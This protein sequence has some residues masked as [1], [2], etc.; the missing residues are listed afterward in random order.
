M[1]ENDIG[2]VRAGFGHVTT[3]VSKMVGG[4]ATL[5]F[6]AYQKWQGEDI[7]KKQIEAYV[8]LDLAISGSGAAVRDVR[9][10]G[11]LKYKIF[12]L[13]GLTVVESR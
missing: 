7:I 8:D 6:Q 13:T 3:S 1:S 11:F 4:V 2:Y 12:E 10:G 5:G 9:L